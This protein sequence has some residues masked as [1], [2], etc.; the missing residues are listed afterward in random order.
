MTRNAISAEDVVV[1]FRPYH[2]T[3][4]TLRRSLAH[5]RIKADPVTALAGVSF[6]VPKGVALG[7]VGRNGAGKSTLMRVLAQTLPPDAGRVTVN[8]TASTLLQLGVGFNVQ[9]SGRKNIYLGALAMGMRLSDVEKRVESIIAYADL[10]SAIDR[11][12]KTYS[13]GMFSR[14]AFSVG[15]A[16]DPDILLLDEVLAVGD[17]EFREKSMQ[18]MKEMLAASGTI[19]F[20]S[21]AAQAV[22]ELC[23]QAL[24]LD[25][26]RIVDMGPADD[27]VD[28]YVASTRLPKT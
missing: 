7:V 23:S 11:P 6:E 18:T 21:H 1:R 4:P 22:K 19:V 26:G 5:R 17:Q 10:G 12:L 2:E 8:G 15:M 14:L 3:A 9:L 25:Q 28:S 27:I 13:S 16:Q 20:V 24:W